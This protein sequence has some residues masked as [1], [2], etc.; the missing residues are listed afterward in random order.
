MQAKFENVK[1][2]ATYARAA[3]RGE[4]VAAKIGSDPSDP[5]DA[6]RWVVVSLPGGRFAPCA[7]VNANLAGGPGRF[8]GFANVC[9]VN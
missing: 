7:I 6:Y 8:I 9:V 4:E 2:Y 1:G 5:R 3:K